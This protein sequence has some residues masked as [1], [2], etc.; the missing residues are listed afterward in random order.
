MPPQPQ[1]AAPLISSDTLNSRPTRLIY[2]IP[3]AAD[4]L[5]DVEYFVNGGARERAREEKERRAEA[6]ECF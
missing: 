1:P 6:G 5:G 2:R 3:D 4:A